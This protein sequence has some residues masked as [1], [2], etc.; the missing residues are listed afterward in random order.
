VAEAIAGQTAELDVTEV[1]AA[2]G[3]VTREDESGDLQVLVVHRSRYADWSFPKGKLDSDETF[4]AAAIREVAEETGL[5]CRLVTELAPIRY[6]DAAGRPKIVRY[7]HM[8]PAAGDIGD[9]TFN[10]EIDDLRWVSREEAATLLSYA[11][12]RDLLARFE[13]ERS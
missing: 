9:Y 8:V 5:V 3:L 2:G 10:A 12:D 7:W 1:E 11:H 13:T 6:Q 4:E